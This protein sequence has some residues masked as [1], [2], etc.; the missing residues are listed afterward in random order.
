MMNS[1]Q[2]ESGSLVCRWSGLV[3][4][5]SPAVLASLHEGYERFVPP[6]PNFAAH[7]LL[8]SGEWFVPWNY[9][10]SVPCGRIAG[11]EALV[12]GACERHD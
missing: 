11:A 3:E 8:G 10:W 6:M 7:S 12:F 4:P 2:S 5:P 1:W 9:R